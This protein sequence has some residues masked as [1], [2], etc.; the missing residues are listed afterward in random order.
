M[1]IP[2]IFK[3]LLFGVFPAWLVCY[4]VLLWCHPVAQFEN[5]AA[6]FYHWEKKENHLNAAT[7]ALA[8]V[9]PGKPGFIWHARFL[10]HYVNLTQREKVLA[11][12]IAN[13]VMGDVYVH[14]QKLSHHPM[15]VQ[16]YTGV[17]GNCIL[18][19]AQ[20]NTDTLIAAYSKLDRLDTLTLPY[21]NELKGDIS[22][23]LYNDAGAE[24]A[25]R[26][27]LE[28]NPYNAT[29]YSKLLAMLVSNGKLAD[30]RHYLNLADKQNVALNISQKRFFAFMVS[31]RLWIKNIYAPVFDTSK[32]MEWLVAALIFTVWVVLLF[33]LDVFSEVSYAAKTL[34]LLL[35]IILAP[36]V[37]MLYDVVYYYTGYTDLNPF[38]DEILFTGIIEETGKF[39]PVLLLLGLAPRLLKTPLS[40]LLCAGFSALAFSLTENILYFGHYYDVSIASGRAILSTALHLVTTSVLAYGIVIVKYNHRAWWYIPL[41][42]V[43]AIATHGLYNAF[44]HYGL[45]I[46]SIVLVIAGIFAWGSF[47]NNCLNNSPA[48]SATVPARFQQKTI[49]LTGGLAFIVIIE[50]I[51]TSLS[52]GFEHGEP[53]FFSALFSTGWLILLMPLSFMRL[54]LVQHKWRFIDFAGFSEISLF[55]NPAG[56]KI[57]LVTHTSNSLLA[58]SEVVEARVVKKIKGSDDENWY[59]IHTSNT[60]L[61]YALVRFKEYGEN[62]H[63]FNVYMYLRVAQSTMPE[64]YFDVKQ[65]PFVCFVVMKPI[66]AA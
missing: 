32:R 4:L 2:V 59:F 47:V 20:K 35:G 54:E 6:A 29:A 12:A 26:R 48:F 21:I 31:P 5:K 43:I 8:L 13:P 38:L 3:F 64:P 41:C 45:T 66:V 11:D 65:Y 39:I 49:W 9:E 42:F 22:T 14:Y 24:K 17:Y 15:P 63:D 60:N 62:F 23:T 34:A 1:K 55:G 16:K 33:M 58:A 36:L 53:V 10:R 61:P 27:E 37:I 50:F 30:A 46:V 18:S 51:A 56:K 19:L 44:L 28:I 25:Y 7:S 57:A 40:L 52:L